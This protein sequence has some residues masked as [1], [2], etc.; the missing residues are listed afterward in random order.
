MA[1]KKAV[2]EKLIPGLLL[3]ELT[4]IEAAQQKVRADINALPQG[5]GQLSKV[6][7][8]LDGAEKLLMELKRCYA[9]AE[10]Q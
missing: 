3:S 9:W 1:R 6:A 2:K 8:L 7:R 10:K 5:A 4:E